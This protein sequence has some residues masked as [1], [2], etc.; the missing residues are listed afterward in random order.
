MLELTPKAAHYRH[1][2]SCLSRRVM[3]KICKMPECGGGGG[4]N[5]TAAL[6]MTY[7]LLPYTIVVVWVSA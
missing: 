3:T 1:Q 4:L 6:S 2:G 5:S 7:D